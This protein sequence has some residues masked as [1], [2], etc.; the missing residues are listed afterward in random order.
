[1]KSYRK[2]LN[3][4]GDIINTL[5]LFLCV[6]R[7]SGGIYSRQ[8]FPELI[9]VCVEAHICC[10]TGALKKILY[11]SAVVC[12]VNYAPV[13]GGY[14]LTFTGGETLTIKNGAQGEKGEYFCRWQ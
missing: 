3:I 4:I 1:M 9:E 13:E 6:F 11:I 8:S 10:N 14:L 5:L 7:R 12:G 2:Y